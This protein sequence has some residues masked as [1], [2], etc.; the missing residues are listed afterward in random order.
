MLGFD[1]AQDVTLAQAS[2]IKCLRCTNT[3]CTALRVKTGHAGWRRLQQIHGVTFRRRVIAKIERGALGEQWVACLQ[4][5]ARDVA[6]ANRT[7][8]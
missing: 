3:Q 6:P 8:S 1:W 2:N 7:G 5:V 4:F